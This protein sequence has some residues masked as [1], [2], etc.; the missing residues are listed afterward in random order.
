VTTKE[1]SILY[2]GDDMKEF[3]A[4]IGERNS[5]KSTIIVSLTGCKGITYQGKVFEANTHENVYVMASS[6]QESGMKLIRLVKILLDVLSDPLCRGLVMAIQPTDAQIRLSLKKILT[7][8][9]RIGG[10]NQHLFVIDP[11]YNNTIV[12]QRALSKHNSQL[13]VISSAIMLDGRRNALKSA[14]DINNIT[15]IMY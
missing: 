11:H 12:S 15:H 9:C 2:E 13:S 1:L 7:V 14:N 8:I 4:V 3:V 5:G 6:P 10:Y